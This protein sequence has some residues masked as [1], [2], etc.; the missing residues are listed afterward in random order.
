M[1][2]R[3]WALPVGPRSA[4]NGSR[5]RTEFPT[6][7]GFG[8]LRRRRGLPGYPS[9]GE[10]VHDWVEN[11]HASTAFF[12]AHGIAAGLGL[13]DQ[14]ADRSVAAAI[15]DGAMT[16]GLAREGLNNPA[17]RPN[18]RW[19]SSSTMVSLGSGGVKR[20]LPATPADV[21]VDFSRTG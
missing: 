12:R 7:G 8:S 1:S 11:S 17:G 9:R 2:A 16:G 10:S 15:G 19:W 3:P 20:V 4:A 18:C 5:A 14:W 6:G 13:H 21:G